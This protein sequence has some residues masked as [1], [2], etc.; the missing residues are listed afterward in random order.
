MMNENEQEPI[1][2]GH[3]VIAESQCDGRHTAR[4]A[5]SPG[6]ARDTHVG[7]KMFMMSWT[8]IIT[9]EPKGKRI[10]LQTAGGNWMCPP[11]SEWRTHEV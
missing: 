3:S 2:G 8:K 5:A 10:R 6:S 4:Q 11:D 9:A 7:R 1:P